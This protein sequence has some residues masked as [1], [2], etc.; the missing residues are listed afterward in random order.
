MDIDFLH[1]PLG[2]SLGHIAKRYVGILYKRLSHLK[3]G[4][5]FIVLLIID[6]GE[7]MLTQQEIADSCGLDK[8]NV[9]RIIDSLSANK[10]VKRVK[11]P[12]DRRAYL[13]QLTAK[14]RKTMP[15]INKIVK[16]LNELAFGGL[17]ERQINGFFKTLDTI[18]NNIS[19]LPS[20][21]LVMSLKGKEKKK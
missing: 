9:L 5:Y 20:E 19:D 1:I 6:K 15:E 4:P 3:A 14:G 17:S 10:I 13:I 2:R 11:K 8:T 16:E 18:N 7:G 12:D 21:S